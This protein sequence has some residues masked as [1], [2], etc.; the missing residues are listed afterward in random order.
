M[1]GLAGYKG[2]LYVGAQTSTT[3]TNEAMSEPLAD[4]LLFQVTNAAKSMWDDTAV[5]TVQRDQGTGTWIAATAGTYEIDYAIGRVRFLTALGAS[6]AVR[7]S[8]KYFTKTKVAGAKE[9]SLD[10]E[11]SIEDDTEF[12]SAWETGVAVLGKGAGSVKL[13]WQN[14]AWMTQI[15]STTPRLVLA[16]YTDYA[17]N[18]RYEFGA[19]LTKDSVG[20]SVK[21]LLEEDLAFQSTGR[22]FYT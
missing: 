6:E 8:G 11:R 20:A 22:I 2:D 12:G 10:I 21:G 16:L 19:L 5:T 17:N 3:F 18:R 7:V 9:W 4:N 14:A 13:N 1:A 15:A